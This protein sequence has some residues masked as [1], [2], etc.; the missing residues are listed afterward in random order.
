[1]RAAARDRGVRF[2]ITYPNAD[3][4]SRAIV[5]LWER[6]AADHPDSVAVR[7]LGHKRYLSALAGLD[8]M[9]GNSS[10]GL[11][12]APSFNLPVVNVGERQAGRERG[13]NVIDV[14][15]RAQAIATG[16][17][18]ALAYDRRRPIDNPYGGD[19]R[20]SERL[21]D[22]L[23]LQLSGRTRGELLHKRFIDLS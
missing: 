16:L 18:A 17:E 5:D 21:V 3:A 10:S 9:L 19:G 14:E 11:V 23:E 4:G 13:A 2:V 7:S 6:F 22:F 1:L 20:A 8:F 15:P 12:E